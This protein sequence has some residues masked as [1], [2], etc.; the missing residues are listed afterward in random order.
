MNALCTSFA[1]CGPDA[2]SLVWTLE[3]A[4]A[5]FGSFEALVEALKILHAARV[6]TRQHARL[7]SS[8]RLFFVFVLFLFLTQPDRLVLI[9]QPYACTSDLSPTLVCDARKVARRRAHGDG[10]CLL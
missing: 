2:L 4:G 3:S 6:S 1:G 10:F 9:F 7:V 8:T 5:R